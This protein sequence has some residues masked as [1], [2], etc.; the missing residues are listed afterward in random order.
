MGPHEVELRLDVGVTLDLDRAVRRRCEAMP[1]VHVERFRV[2]QRVRHLLR[3]VGDGG[4]VRREASAPTPGPFDPDPEAGVV[5]RDARWIDD[6]LVADEAGEQARP[7]G[8]DHQQRGGAHRVAEAEQRSFGAEFQR[9]DHREQVLRTALPTVVEAV[10]RGRVA[11][12]PHVD[13]DPAKAVEVLEHRVVDPPVESGGVT[14]DQVGAIAAE[15]VDG[16]FDAVGGLDAV[17]GNRFEH[18]PGK[19]AAS[20][21][22]PRCRIGRCPSM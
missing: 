14:G 17:D 13:A 9:V 6:R 21:S 5:V 15:V 18:R 16:E 20:G 19:L 2:D 12:P 1:D 22:G 10:R 3:V 4:F 11:V 7:P 8:R